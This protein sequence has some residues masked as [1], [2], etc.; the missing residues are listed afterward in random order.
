MVR[1]KEKIKILTIF[2]LLGISCFLNYY[3]HIVLKTGIIYT[4][5]FYIPII[6]ACIWWRRKGLLVAIF[7]AVMLIFSHLF[8]RVH[9]A[10][11]SDYIRALMFIVIASVVAALSEKI[12]K[13]HEETERQKNFS[14]NIITT[15]PQSLII[16]DKDL[17]IKKANLAFYQLFQT[18]PEKAMGSSLCDLLQ[19]KDGKLKNELTRI[20]GT[21]D[22]LKD[23]EIVYQSEKLGKRVLN[24]IAKGMIIDEEEVILIQDITER[25]KAEEALRESE[26]RLIQSEKLSIIGELATGV[27]H[28]VRNPLATI[29]LIT[30]HLER[31][32]ADN[33]Q[34]EKLKTIQRNINRIDKIVYGLLNISRP[35]RSNF[36]Y[37][38]VNEILDRLGSILENLPSENI[39]IIK[40]YEPKLPQ[41]WFNSDC[42]E[43]VFLNLISNAMRAMKSGGE[44]YI[45]TSFN[46]TRKGII[47]KFEDTGVGIPEENLKKIFNP[48]FTTY[49]EGTGLGLSICQNIINEH[50]GNI[51]V[52]SK[53]G[54]GTTFT[55]FLPLEKRKEKKQVVD[56][57]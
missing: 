52:E 38:N 43:Q 47:I 27:A 40:K 23:F 53:L 24:I 30:Q 22:I 3:F 18:K 39:K 4:H 54:K 11:I 44:L 42:L 29:R 45:T 10:D 33:Y 34:I 17:R 57:I 36:A 50:K 32:C 37:H 19:D 25:K 48:F 1:E 5:F 2:I 31:K 16:L 46:S 13:G 7:L 14:E 8:F 28:E 12:T 15:V 6:F 56:G 55:I 26:A 51:S 9:A 41:I 35:P 20:I 21:K 49:K